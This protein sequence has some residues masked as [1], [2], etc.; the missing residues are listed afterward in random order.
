MSAIDRLV[1]QL[2]PQAVRFVDCSDGKRVAVN[3]RKVFY[4][5]EI[6]TAARV[7]CEI[8]GDGNIVRV[9]GS[10][11][12]VSDRLYNANSRQWEEGRDGD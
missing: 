5:K 2:Q 11:E 12:Y 9:K 6:N 4:I 10:L 8:H 3:Y 1:R 7:G